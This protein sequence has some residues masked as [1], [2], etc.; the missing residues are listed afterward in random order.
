[1]DPQR[2]ALQARPVRTRGPAAVPGRDR[3]TTG[4]TLVRL[5]PDERTAWEHDG[6]LV[7]HG[8]FTPEEVDEIA[9]ACEELCRDLADAEGTQNRNKIRVSRDYVFEPDATRGIFIKW[10]PGAIDEIQGVEPCAHLHP[11][12]QKYAE[13]PSFVEPSKDILG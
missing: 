5:T 1:M 10:E 3:P 7:R 12:L 9:T 13:H 2:E 11:V 6:F 4:G 8:A